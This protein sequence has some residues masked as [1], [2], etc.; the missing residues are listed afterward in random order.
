[1]CLTNS[2]IVEYLSNGY[3]IPEISIEVNINIKTLEKR[4]YV[5]KKVSN[6]DTAA[7]LVA[8]YIR[9]KIID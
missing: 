1:M 5:L 9:K 6:S 4:I 8:N 3:T 2:K 7:H